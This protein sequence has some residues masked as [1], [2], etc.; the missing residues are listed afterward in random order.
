VVEGVAYPVETQ[1]YDDGSV[2]NCR[3]ILDGMVDVEGV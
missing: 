3:F 1:S 2:F